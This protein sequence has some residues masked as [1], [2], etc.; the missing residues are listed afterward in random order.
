[1]SISVLF[2][3]QT[4]VKGEVDFSPTQRNTFISRPE[5]KSSRN[6]PRFTRMRSSAGTSYNDS[7]VWRLKN[8]KRP[9][10]F[11]AAASLFTN[12]SWNRSSICSGRSSRSAGRAQWRVNPQPPFRASSA[13]SR[14][15]IWKSTACRW[16]CWAR[17]RPLMPP[18][19]IRMGLGITASSHEWV[20]V[21][22]ER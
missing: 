14:S 22:V 10:S 1:M 6:R 18:P 3:Y 20:L 4:S 15:K 7:P 8:W 2:H 9:T 12:V 17:I 13:E 5:V 19:M 16:R 21:S 11:L